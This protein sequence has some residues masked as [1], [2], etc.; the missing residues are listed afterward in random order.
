MRVLVVNAVALLLI[1]GV[2]VF[3][4]DSGRSKGEGLSADADTA[5]SESFTLG[6]TDGHDLPPS[7]IGRVAVGTVAPDFVLES[8]SGYFERLSEY[9]GSKNVILVFY[10]GHW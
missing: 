4:L 3:Y 7:E 8:Y 6:P 1:L 10:R 2:A 5:E 9:R